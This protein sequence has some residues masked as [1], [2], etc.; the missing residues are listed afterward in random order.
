VV[1]DGIASKT[2]RL[3]NKEIYLNFY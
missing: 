2:L 3:Q 1:E